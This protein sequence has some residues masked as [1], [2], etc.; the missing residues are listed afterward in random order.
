MF[1]FDH[2]ILLEVLAHI[3]SMLWKHSHIIQ[4][5]QL[6]VNVF[7]KLIQIHGA[8]KMTKKYFFRFFKP[9]IAIS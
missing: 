8:S 1:K 2:G 3:L 9:R 7:Q 6:S 4:D 5:V